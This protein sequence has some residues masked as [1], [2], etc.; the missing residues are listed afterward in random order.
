MTIR[1]AI[2]IMWRYLLLVF[3]SCLCAFVISQET[4]ARTADAGALTVTTALQTWRDDK[5]GRSLPVRILAA[6]T[7]LKSSPVIL[8]SHGLG[9]SREGGKLWGEHWASHGY[10]VVHLQHLGSDE[11]IWKDKR[12]QSAVDGMKSA[13]NMTNLGLRI[14]DVQFAIDEIIH[15]QQQ[16]DTLFANADTTR[17]GLAGHSFGA[18]TTLAIAGQVSPSVGGVSGL[19]KRVSA[20]IVLS[21]NARNKQNLDRQFGGINIP[22]MS[23]TGTADGSVLNDGTVVSDRTLP[24]KHLRAGDKY[25]LV[26]DGG[27]HMVFGGHAVHKSRVDSVVDKRVN[28]VVKSATLAYWDATLRANVDAAKWMKAQNGLQAGLE[29]GDRYEYK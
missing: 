26:L 9:G 24:Y 28:Q 10:I 5:R 14:G 16:G 17:I 21:P 3:V 13:M 11:S 1:K 27:D 12:G 22:V 18:Q 6:A 4:Q 7:P 2:P 20:V 29:N 25:L 8:F 19:D 15:R 23:I